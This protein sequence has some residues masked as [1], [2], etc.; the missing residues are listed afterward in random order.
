MQAPKM[1][2]VQTRPNLEKFVI[3]L[4]GDDEIVVTD[5]NLPIV[6]KIK[7]IYH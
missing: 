4:V 2:E 1:L 6:L 7:I 3:D 5:V